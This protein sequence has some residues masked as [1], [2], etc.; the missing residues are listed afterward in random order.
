MLYFLKYCIHPF[1]EV[2][3]YSVIVCLSVCLSKLKWLQAGLGA[4]PAHVES[5]SVLQQAETAETEAEV[6]VVGSPV[7]SQEAGGFVQVRTI[8]LRW[9]TIRRRHELSVAAH[10]LSDA[11]LQKNMYW[12]LLLLYCTVFAF[13]SLYCHYCHM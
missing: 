12:V 13:I 5:Q 11:A 2:L 6:D 1:V 3:L 8:R 9:R 4:V 10:E 7:I